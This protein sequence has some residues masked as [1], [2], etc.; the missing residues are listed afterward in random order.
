MKWGTALGLCL[1]LLAIACTMTKQTPA[2]SGYAFSTNDLT[3]ITWQGQTIYTGK[4]AVVTVSPDGRSVAW[5]VQE[6]AT[7]RDGDRKKEPIY[8]GTL[9]V[10]YDGRPP[11]VV[12]ETR[13]SRGFETPD[14]LPDEGIIWR[15]TEFKW[16]STSEYLYFTTLPWSSRSL[17]WRVKR[18]EAV[19]RAIAL[20]WEYR[21]LKKLRGPDWVEVR[22]T[23][24]ERQTFDVSGGCRDWSTTYIYTPEDM[25]VEKYVSPKMRRSIGKDWPKE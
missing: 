14:P 7:Y 18:G 23:N 2:R 15:P 17:L 19:P 1:V 21:L 22:E 16:D 8:A 3:I 9:Y 10:A 25:A 20:E 5:T 11:A 4:T 13:E 6:I 12:P 24:Y